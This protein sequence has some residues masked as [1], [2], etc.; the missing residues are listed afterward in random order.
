MSC[1]TLNMDACHVIVAEDN[2][3]NLEVVKTFLENG[4]DNVTVFWAS[5]GQKALDM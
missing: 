4:S 2:P 3:F 5:N 1:Q